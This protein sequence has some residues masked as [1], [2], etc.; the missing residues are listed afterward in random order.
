[1]IPTHTS[2][3][4]I[5][6]LV[7]DPYLPCRALLINCLRGPSQPCIL[8]LTGV[9]PSLTLLTA[10]LVLVS[11]CDRRHQRQGLLVAQ[12]HRDMTIHKYGMRRS[13]SIVGSITF[14]RLSF[15]RQSIFST[16]L[17]IM[18]HHA[19]SRPM[20]QCQWSVHSLPNVAVTSP[21]VPLHPM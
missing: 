20:S 6:F 16:T 5:I 17:L 9:A 10:V 15:S 21:K 3:H 18:F 12:H 1:L 14:T 11:D 8:L 4:H 7:V 13:T 19:Q 2:P